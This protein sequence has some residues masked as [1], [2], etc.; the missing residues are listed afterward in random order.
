MDR[1]VRL[2][3]AIV[4]LRW[5]A[6]VSILVL[7]VWSSG[8]RLAEPS[9]YLPTA[10]AI[11][12]NS[13]CTYLAFNRNTPHSTLMTAA[14]LTTV[15]DILVISL[16]AKSYTYVFG[17]IYLLYAFIA[18]DT[19]V[20]FEL[21]GSLL[22]GLGVAIG[23]GYVT[24]VGGV[25]NAEVSVYNVLG[26][27]VFFLLLGCGMGYLARELR[28]E[29]EGRHELAA[30]YEISRV[31]SVTLDLNEILSFVI[32]KAREQFRALGAA[33]TLLDGES[34]L[35]TVEALA[36][37]VSHLAEKSSIPLD[38][39][40][41]GKVAS[42]GQPLR[43]SLR[44]GPW[45][46]LSGESGRKSTLCV[47]LI[48]RGSTLGTLTLT[49]N[50]YRPEFDDND[51][52][53]AL[54]FATQAATSIENIRLYHDLQHLA[55]STM[56]ALAAAIDAKDSYTR[57]HSERLTTLA[58]GLADQLGLSDAE[59][60][61]IQYAAALHDI[62][63]IAIS[64]S[65]LQKP[66]PLTSEEWEIMRTHP[67]RGARMVESI[68]FLRDAVPLIL[69][70]HE[71]F[72]GRGYPQGLAG[73]AIPLGARIL[74]VVDAWEA[75]TSDRAYRPALTRAEAAAELVRNAGK[76]FDPDLV[77]AFLVWV[78]RHYGVVESGEC[79]L[80]TSGANGRGGDP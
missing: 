35:M 74:G 66:G 7:A 67:A 57:G 10:I 76:Q 75:M 40:I 61:A 64:D 20:R 5:L 43:T 38:E 39:G 2:E 78:E 4:G 28:Q 17:D 47:P 63:K 14:A 48:S 19:A 42:S 41:E 30:L 12:Y 46:P 29:R 25:A 70:H 26:R 54:T 52:R 1:A 65:I 9:F 72:D 56:T 37:Q 24:L 58:L 15:L 16:L 36:G 8:N 13:A 60:K 27:L 53:L 69:H 34:G 31:A 21:K 18:V 77:S 33:V 50:G 51:L 73:E 44:S 80:V 55:L 79:E 6:V 71:R 59:R 22:G 45:R 23:Y 62:G 11:L 32:A 3:Q 68:E 49:S